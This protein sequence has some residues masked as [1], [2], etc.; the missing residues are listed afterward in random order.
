MPLF[1]RYRLVPS[2]P[3]PLQH[4]LNQCKSNNLS[5]NVHYWWKEKY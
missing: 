2:K 3:Y 4:I 5:P 1:N